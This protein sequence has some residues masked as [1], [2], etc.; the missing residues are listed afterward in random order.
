[1]EMIILG[2]GGSNPPPRPGCQCRVCR[3]ARETGIPA[4][5][6]RASLFVN[7][8]SLLISASLDLRRQLNRENIDLVQNLIIPSWEHEHTAGLCELES[9]NYDI[10]SDSAIWDPIQVFVPPADDNAT[11]NLRLLQ[12]YQNELG[13]IDLIEMRDCGQFSIGDLNILPVKIEN[14][15]LFYFIIFNS[16]GK[17]VYVPGRYKE[18]SAISEAADPDYFIAPCFWWEDSTVYKR[19]IINP[20]LL[21]EYSTFEQMLEE[22]GNLRARKILLT[23]IEEDYGMSH[24]DLITL[25]TAKYDYYPLEISFDGQRLSI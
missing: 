9:L 25:P 15:G 4:A 14:T 6:S 2:S 19:S 1:M 17:I 11:G 10:I 5:R 16:A 13:I 23:H 18:F 20:A 24:T 12:K 3:E 7:D 21:G 8:Q 22:A